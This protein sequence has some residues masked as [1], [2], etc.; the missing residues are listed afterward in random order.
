MEKCIALEYEYLQRD[1]AR[2]EEAL[3]KFTQDSKKIYEELDSLHGIWEG[4]AHEFYES[5]VKNDKAFIRS[6]ATALRL[7]KE[8]L[9][10]SEKIYRRREDSVRT[11]INQI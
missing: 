4:P 6:M 9:L 10:Q 8:V 2:F 3:E 5:Q 11:I 1:I 7:Y